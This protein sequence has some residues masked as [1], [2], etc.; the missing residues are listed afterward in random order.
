VADY[1]IETP[2]IGMRFVK[3]I[4]DDRE[5]RILQQ[6]WGLVTYRELPDGGRHCVEATSIWR[7]VPLVE[8]AANG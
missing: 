7:D 5:L 6:C 1:Q 3:R 4:V 8:D 2:Q